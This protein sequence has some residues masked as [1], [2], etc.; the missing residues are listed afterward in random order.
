MREDT[1]KIDIIDGFS[2]NIGWKLSEI[3]GKSK[4]MSVDIGIL[5]LP[6]FKSKTSRKLSAS[7]MNGFVFYMWEY[8]VIGQFHLSHA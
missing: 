1:W 2:R 7:S 8:F 6:A 3:G 5:L 4:F